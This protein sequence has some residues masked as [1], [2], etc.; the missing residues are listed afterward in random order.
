MLE[1]YLAL[2]V[3]ESY[4]GEFS[5]RETKTLWKLSPGWNKNKGGGGGFSRRRPPLSTNIKPLLGVYEANCPF[6]L[7]VGKWCTL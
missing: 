7:E 4:R 2:Y 3:R 6:G 1:R 5:E